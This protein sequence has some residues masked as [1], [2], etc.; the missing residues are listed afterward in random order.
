MHHSYADDTQ[1]YVHC[2]NTAHGRRIAIEQLQNCLSDISQWMKCNALQLNQ[3]KTELVLF[4][5]NNENTQIELY[6]I[7]GK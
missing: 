1:I 3:E 2:D 7:V 4:A 6:V 5:N